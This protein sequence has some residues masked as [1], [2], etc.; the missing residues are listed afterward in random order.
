MTADLPSLLGARLHDF[1]IRR[2]FRDIGG[3]PSVQEEEDGTYYEFLR[4]GISLLFDLDSRLKAIHLYSSGRDE[5]SE[6]VGNVP[7]GLTFRDRKEEVIRKLGNPTRSGG[8]EKTLLADRIAE[9]VRYDYTN[10]SLHAEFS[11]PRGTVSLVTVIS[12]EA[13]PV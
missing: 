2:F 11:E 5:Y 6:Y 12:P 8:G 13:V 3:Q 10:Y 7:G 4:S 9:W 1:E